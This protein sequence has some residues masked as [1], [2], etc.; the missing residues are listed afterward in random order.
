[1]QLFRDSQPALHIAKNSACHDGTK[2]IKLDCHFILEKV[3]S[4]IITFAH[5]NSQHQ[6]V[7]ILTK[8]LG[9]QQFRYLKSKLGMANMHSLTEG[10]VLEETMICYQYCACISIEC[11]HLMFS[12]G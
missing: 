3:V 8:A 6:P 11:N 12:L 2:H 7:D 1:M 4:R 5:V 9:K 10:A